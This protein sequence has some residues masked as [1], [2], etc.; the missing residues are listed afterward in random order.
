MSNISPSNIMGHRVIGRIG[1]KLEFGYQRGRAFRG[2]R[3][4]GGK[5]AAK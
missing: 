1:Q 3:A 4:D 2:S 5:G